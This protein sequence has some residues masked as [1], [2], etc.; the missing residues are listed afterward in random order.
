MIAKVTAANVIPHSLA[1]NLNQEQLKE[2]PE[3]KDST[4]ESRYLH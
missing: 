1:P 3:Q 2:N 4:T